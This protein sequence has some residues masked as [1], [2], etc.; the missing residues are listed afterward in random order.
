MVF[1]IWAPPYDSHSGGIIALHKLGEILSNY[2]EKVFISNAT[3]FTSN[4]KVISYEDII[5]LNMNEVVVIYP[6]IVV[7]NPYNAKYVVRW[8]LNTPGIIGGDGI[9]GEHDLVYKYSNY[10]KALDESRVKGEL[11]T[12]DLKLNIFYNKNQERSGECYMVRK[13]AH[14]VL[15][16]HKNEAINLDHNPADE[17][18]A[19]VFNKC[20]YFICYDSMCF[21]NHQAALCGCIPIIVPD[22]GV[23]KEEFINKSSINKYGIAYGF[24]DIEYAKNTQHLMKEYLIEMENESKEQIKTLI[25]D[26]YNLVGITK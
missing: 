21:H 10:F 11:R 1:L 24:D 20:E 17:H 13:G 7:G 19:N 9:Y 16:K 26:C 8:I 4:A 18:L 23:S 12:F 6:E 2:G 3:S 22:D 25:K 5:K 14:K 15:N